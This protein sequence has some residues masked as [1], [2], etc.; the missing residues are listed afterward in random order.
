MLVCTYPSDL[1]VTSQVAVRELLV[2]YSAGNFGIVEAARPRLRTVSNIAR[3]RDELD[4]IAA[5]WP[6]VVVAIFSLEVAKMTIDQAI[7]QRPSTARDRSSVD[8]R[9]LGAHIEG[10]IE[11][12]CSQFK[13]TGVSGALRRDWNLAAL[14]LALGPASMLRGALEYPVVIF[15]PAAFSFHEHVRHARES[16]STDPFVLYKWGAIQEIM[17]HIAL[18]SDG[19][20]HFPSFEPTHSM[21]RRSD[22]QEWWPGGATR[23]EIAEAFEVARLEPELRFDALLRLGRVRSWLGENQEALQ[24]W[25]AVAR[26]DVNPERIYLAHLFKGRALLDSKRFAEAAA[27]FAAALQLR[28]N[29]QSAAVPLAALN[30]LAGK[31]AEAANIVGQVLQRPTQDSDPWLGY[32]AP[33]YR[34]WPIRLQR[35]RAAIQ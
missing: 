33:G 1:G 32:L 28:P 27:E 25:A 14:T 26:D 11:V 34:D 13:R 19:V 7:E 16:F 21:R 6:P 10:I 18:Y 35:L 29:T 9:L 8:H 2:A 31:R 17:I 20:V 30:Y 3:F 15:A 5:K 23:R 4:G 24:L 12:G 22:G